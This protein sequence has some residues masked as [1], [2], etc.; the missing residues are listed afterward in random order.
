MTSLLGSKKCSLT[1]VNSAFL[2]LSRLVLAGFTKLDGQG[3]SV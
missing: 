2:E 1:A 3:N